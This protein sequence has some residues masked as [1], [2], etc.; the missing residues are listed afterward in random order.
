LAHLYQ[1][2]RTGFIVILLITICLI[3][4]YG[5]MNTP[6]AKLSLANG[7]ASA[8]TACY[9]G[10]LNG[11][12]ASQAAASSLLLLT[13]IRDHNGHPIDVISGTGT[14]IANSASN[15]KNYNRI[16]TAFHVAYPEL[17]AGEK[18]DGKL[19]VISSGGDF[20]GWAHPEGQATSHGV[21]LTNDMA[22]LD[23]AIFSNAGKNLYPH[24]MG[25][26]IAHRL[27][28]AP[29]SAFIS[30]PSGLSE[31]G[32][33]AGV[34]DQSGNL[35]GVVSLSAKL[36]ALPGSMIG[37]W[38]D[39]SSIVVSGIPAG[40]KNNQ[41][42]QE[43]PHASNTFVAPFTSMILSNLGRAGLDSSFYKEA[44]QDTM[45]ESFQA[46]VLGYP[47]MHCIAFEAAFR[48]FD[49]NDAS[50]FAPVSMPP[51]LLDPEW[52]DVNK[53]DISLH[54]LL[55]ILS[56]KGGEEG[57]QFT[58]IQNKFQNVKLV[59]ANNGL[60]EATSVIL[61]RDGYIKEAAWLMRAVVLADQKSRFLIIGN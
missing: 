28:L 2:W 38:P 13:I 34:F 7:N 26:H 12:V 25:V 11:V 1:K 46:V 10:Q 39:M 31:G 35:R 42:S 20:L 9:G 8:N 32:S 47:Q 16:V 15:G 5:L 45:K 49:S 44:S 22:I 14:V 50:Q 48:P 27:S 59:D 58:E 24:I 61:A 41:I 43:L 33:G 60:A 40:Y 37:Q 56:Q 52:M 6:S 53:A 17:S 57:R 21:I 3:A 18:S 19:A 23:M 36:R 51:L 55:I 54:K 29:L 4:T 30:T